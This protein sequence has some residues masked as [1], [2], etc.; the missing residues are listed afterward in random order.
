MLLAVLSPSSASRRSSSIFS[1][2]ARCLIPVAS[3]SSK[4][5]FI[6]CRPSLPMASMTLSRSIGASREEFVVAA[7]IGQG[8]CLEF[9]Q[10]RRH[11]ARCG[12]LIVVVAGQDVEYHVP[13]GRAGG[14]GFGT[15]RGHLL[16]PVDGD[17][18]QDA[19]KLAV[20]VGFGAEQLPHLGKGL[21][22]VPVPEGGAVAQGAGFA[23]Q[24]FQV[25]PGVIDDLV[26]AELA[27][28]SANNVTVMDDDD[29]V[30]VGPDHGRFADRCGVDA[31]AVVVIGHQGGGRDTGRQFLVAVKG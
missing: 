28:M 17:G 10:M 20:A 30:G 12:K 23:L 3:T 9:R 7:A 18:T 11:L 31:V 19:D 6:P 22:Q 2:V 16:K 4:T 5:L 15:C 27:P 21:R 24:D 1:G 8:L 13:T 14:N 25:V 26:P 29:S